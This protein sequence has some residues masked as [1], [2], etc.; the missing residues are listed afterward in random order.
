ML[1]NPG[2]ATALTLQGRAAAESL[3]IDSCVVERLTGKTTDPVTGVVSDQWDQV[4]AGRCKV[5][6]RL[7]AST[8][9]LSGEHVFTVEQLM[10]HLPIAAQS[11]LDD[12]VTIMETELDSDLVGLKLR[13][14]DLARGS[15]RTAD[16]WN[17]ELV[18]G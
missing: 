1:L 12:R 14:K 4:Y 10:V 18:T 9:P 5:Q 8:S 6:G 16:R 7:A 3:M 17:V 15:F 2:D 11:Q 13:L